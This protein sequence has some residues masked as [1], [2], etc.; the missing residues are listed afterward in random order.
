MACCVRLSFAAETIFMDLVILRVLST[1]LMCVRM[2]R[3]LA[4]ALP[5]P[6]FLISLVRQGVC[7]RSAAGAASSLPGTAL[8][9]SRAFNGFPLR[10]SRQPPG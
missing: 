2:A 3:T 5:P 8:S 6:V 4:K 1:L 7:P 10:G 9:T